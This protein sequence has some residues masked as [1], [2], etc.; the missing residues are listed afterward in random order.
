M[1]YSDGESRPQCANPEC[2]KTLTDQ[3]I[4]TWLITLR[5]EV[6]KKENICA[7]CNFEQGGECLLKE[8][9]K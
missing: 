8:C 6:A 3:Q 9:V 5:P 2:L 1:T 4:Y 7:G